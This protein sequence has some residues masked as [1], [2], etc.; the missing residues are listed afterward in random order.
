[1]R[2]IPF[3]HT[4]PYDIHMGDIYVPSCP[5]CHEE[6]VLT[7]LSKEALGQAK[8]GV[9]ARVNMPCCLETIVILEADEDYFWTSKPLR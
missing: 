1:M 5:Y 2:P 6:N 4:W 8:D 9:K 7:N 3:S